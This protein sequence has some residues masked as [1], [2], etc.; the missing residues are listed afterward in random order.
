MIA[1]KIKLGEKKKALM[2]QLERDT[3]FLAK[4]NIMDYS[5]LVG[6]HDR[7]NRPAVQDFHENLVSTT[8]V[9][10]YAEPNITHDNIL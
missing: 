5:L 2:E 3:Q 10:L 4:L 1:V 9:N 7:T 8:F 6:I